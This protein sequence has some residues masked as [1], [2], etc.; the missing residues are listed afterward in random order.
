MH[1]YYEKDANK[2]ALKG[3]KIAVLG[4]GSQG[5]AHANNLKESGYDV[6]VGLHETSRSI[7]KAQEAGLDVASVAE[8]SLTVFRRGSIGVRRT[9]PVHPSACREL[10]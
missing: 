4:Y 5:H 2:E 7:A 6:V 1:I 9:D 8:G 10:D 3:K